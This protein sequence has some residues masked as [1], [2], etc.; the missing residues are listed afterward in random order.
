MFAAW[1][2]RRYFLRQFS[3]PQRRDPP[4]SFSKYFVCSKTMGMCWQTG[5]ASRKDPHS[6]VRTIQ[7]NWQLQKIVPIQVLR[8][9]TSTAASH[10]FVCCIKRSQNSPWLQFL[11]TCSDVGN[12]SMRLARLASYPR[13][14]NCT[15]SRHRVKEFDTNLALA[16]TGFQHARSWAFFG[17]T[18]CSWK[19]S[20][21]SECCSRTQVDWMLHCSSIV[22]V[23]HHLGRFQILEQ[24][25]YSRGSCH[26]R[27][28]EK[29]GR[30]AGNQW[31]RLCQKWL[32]CRNRQDSRNFFTAAL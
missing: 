1:T 12:H 2:Y 17:Q 22:R 27:R 8:C 31:S 3:C 19:Q 4:R 5:C 25:G 26:W 29:G 6:Y 24:C 7:S 20:C 16:P 10:M 23:V 30:V 15:E 28:Q 14:S 32:C 13:N 18:G 11:W 21:S 9:R